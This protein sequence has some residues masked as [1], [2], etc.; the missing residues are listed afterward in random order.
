MARRKTDFVVQDDTSRDNGKVFVLTEMPAARSEKWAM[1]ALLALQRAGVEIPDDAV[2]NGMAGI[3][4]V[5]I[6]ALGKL[7]F[8]EVEYLLDEMFDCIQIKPDPKLSAVRDLIDDDIEE[9]KTRIL[10]RKEVLEL[11]LGFTL[12]GNQSRSAPA[13]PSSE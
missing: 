3:A 4:T 9:V 8:H 2:Q 1:R 13:R 12:A 5:G 6:D 7:N 11:H 10:L